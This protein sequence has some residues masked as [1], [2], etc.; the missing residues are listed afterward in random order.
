[1]KI[2]IISNTLWSIYN[3]RNGLVKALI[4]GGHELFCVGKIDQAQH[5]LEGLG[6]KVVPWGLEARGTNPFLE[7]LSIL[8]ILFILKNLNPDVILTY[9]IKPNIYLGLLN[10]FLGKRLI[11]NITGLGFGFVN[12]KILKYF[13]TSLYRVSLK[14][15]EKV[16]FQNHDDYELFIRSGI[17]DSS[18]ADVLPGSGINL[19]QFVYS[20][21]PRL[22]VGAFRFIFVGRLLREKGIFEL[23]EAFRLVKKSYPLVSLSIIGAPAKSN[24]EGI[25]SV[26]SLTNISGL[27]VTSF[28]EN[29]KEYLRSSHCVILPSYREGVPRSLLEAAAIGRPIITTDSVG[30]REV[31]VDGVNGF[32]CKPKDVESLVAAMEKILSMSYEELVEMG[33]RGR[34]KVEREFDERIVIQKYMDII[35]KRKKL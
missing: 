17:V 5:Q 31:V 26:D 16:F 35:E 34:E 18:K 9:T 1:M 6:C 33:K 15:H 30:C 23:L 19:E 25:D 2:V 12:G 29:V 21:P 11:S 13:L 27:V 10:W 24:L 4:S 20:E 14:K 3:F 32:L 8:K 28:V 7:L 22:D